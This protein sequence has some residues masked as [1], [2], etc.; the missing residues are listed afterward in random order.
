MSAEL[1]VQLA[2]ELAMSLETRQRRALGLAM[3]PESLTLVLGLKHQTDYCQNQ[4]PPEANQSSSIDPEPE[5]L[6][7]A[8]VA[9]SNQSA[10]AEQSA[11]P[12]DLILARSAR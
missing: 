10:L 5:A 4:L 8:V 2:L 11:E 6:A 3:L 7:E 9:N 12:R 1:R